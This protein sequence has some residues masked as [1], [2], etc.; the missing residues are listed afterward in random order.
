M[1]LTPGTVPPP[2]SRGISWLFMA[3]VP[4]LQYG[5]DRIEDGGW[6]IL[7]RDAWGVIPNLAAVWGTGRTAD[8]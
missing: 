1:E 7:R 8:Y 6:V 2:L 3:K 5:V 4:R